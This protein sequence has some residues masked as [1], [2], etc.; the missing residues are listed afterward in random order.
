MTSIKSV[1]NGAPLKYKVFTEG[2]EYKFYSK[3]IAL[4]FMQLTEGYLI[5]I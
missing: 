1:Y 5:K 4:A 3:K 2:K